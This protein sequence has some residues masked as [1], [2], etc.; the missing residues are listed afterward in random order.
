MSNLFVE[1]PHEEQQYLNLIREI[2]NTGTWENTRNGKTKA[3]FGAHMKFSLKDGSIPLLTTK[4]VAWKTCFKE[5]TWFIKGSTS[6]KEL[7]KAWD[8]MPVHT[9]E[10]HALPSSLD[11]L[12]M[13]PH[14]HD[15]YRFNGS[16]TTP[17]CTENVRWLVMKY[18]DTVSK[19][20]IEKFI[21][22]MHH[23]N[24]RPVQPVNARMILK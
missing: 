20:Q 14:S 3:I 4:K 18:F 11:P 7:K 17:P 8:H 12:A 19:E 9:G 1:P 6:N 22:A 2:I 5:L 10:K 21:H 13:L 15:Y 23:P 24:N 16:L